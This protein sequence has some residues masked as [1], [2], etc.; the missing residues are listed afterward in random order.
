MM[1]VA[2]R[3]NAGE[4]AGR[5]SAGLPWHT[6]EA[7]LAKALA[8]CLDEVQRGINPGAAAARHPQARREIRPLLDIAALLWQR[9][10]LLFRGGAA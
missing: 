6:H 7:Y 10:R 8:E 5:S 2:D 1:Q 4:A 9:K 3:R